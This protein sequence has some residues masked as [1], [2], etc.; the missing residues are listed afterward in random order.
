MVRRIHQ[1][2]RLLLELRHISFKAKEQVDGSSHSAALATALESALPFSA[3]RPALPL[4]TGLELEPALVSDLDALI[5]FL[6]CSASSS[7][8]I[9]KSSSASSSVSES[10]S[11]LNSFLATALA[12]PLPRED[13]NE[14]GES[15]ERAAA[16]SFLTAENLPTLNG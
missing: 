2:V 15:S 16:D 7:L 5:A 10:G 14:A 8:S 12:L 6:S 3:A 1:R 13:R 9:A 4:V 11:R